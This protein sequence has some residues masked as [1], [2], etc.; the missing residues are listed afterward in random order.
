MS[1]RITRTG[2]QDRTTNELAVVLAPQ[3]QNI[4]PNP[5][6]PIGGDIT[7]T[8]TVAPEV[9]PAQTASL[10]LSDREVVADPHLAQTNTLV[11][12]I[13][14]AVAGDHFVRLRID[15]IDSVLIDHTTTPPIFDRAQRVTIT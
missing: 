10:L 15:G 3:V 14:D 4:A 12:Q 8:I 7:L 11:F 6:V 9:R 5:A 2:E 1:L 13:E